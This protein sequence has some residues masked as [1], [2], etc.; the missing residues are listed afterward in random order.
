MMVQS[1]HDQAA[2]PWPSPQDADGVCQKLAKRVEARIEAMVPFASTFSTPASERRRVRNANGLLFSIM[3]GRSAGSPG[4]SSSCRSSSSSSRG[5]N[6]SRSSSGSSSSSGS[7]SSSNS[8]NVFENTARGGGGDGGGSDGVT[9]GAHLSNL[10]DQLYAGLGALLEAAK[11]L[12]PGA[13][14]G[15]AA[16][17]AVGETVLLTLKGACALDRAPSTRDTS[18][19]TIPRRTS[20]C[21]H[22]VCAPRLGRKTLD[23][24]ARYEDGVLLVPDCRKLR[25]EIVRSTCMDPAG[26]IRPDYVAYA[27]APIFVDGAPLGTFC[28][29]SRRTLK[30]L[31][32]GAHHTAILRG[33]ADA[34]ATEMVRLCRIA[35]LEDQQRVRRHRGDAPPPSSLPELRPALPSA[36]P[37]PPRATRWSSRRGS[38]GARSPSRGRGGSSRSLSA[39]RRSC[40]ASLLADPAAAAAA[41]A[42]KQAVVPRAS[43]FSFSGRP[44]SSSATAAAADTAGAGAGARVSVGS[45]SSSP[46]AAAARRGRAA[47]SSGGGGAAAVGVN[48]GNN[49]S[50]ESLG[51]PPDPS[52]VLFSNGTEGSGRIVA[53]RRSV[54]EEGT[55]AGAGARPPPV[56]ARRSTAERRGGAGQAAAAAVAASSVSPRGGAAKSRWQRALRKLRLRSRHRRKSVGS[57]EGDNGSSSSL[58]VSRR[59]TAGGEVGSQQVLTERGQ[60]W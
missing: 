20:M 38:S 37:A 53:P 59:R 32:W 51:A 23:G 47:P 16:V 24:G 17:N 26:G 44:R 40:P 9:P 3:A 42:A 29:F 12:V 36:A 22:A 1:P 41:A 46:R 6:T 2:L 33:L 25:Q 5:S 4:R 30:D 13:R 56:L 43:A 57:D 19:S 55:G 54:S 45:S 28:V 35:E 7:G 39:T 31:G 27:G 49:S 18:L 58:D 60:A 14:A 10:E 50:V 15:G 48:G 34:A 21:Q 8:N 11:E 52:G